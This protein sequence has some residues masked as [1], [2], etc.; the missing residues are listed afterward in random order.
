MS[1]P[2][3]GYPLKIRGT[4]QCY[5]AHEMSQILTFLLDFL[6][7]IINFKFYKLISHS[8]I[9]GSFYREY[10]NVTF[11]PRSMSFIRSFLAAHATPP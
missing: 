6:N 4:K 11:T 8:L 2:N 9:N 7:V 3:G 5:I 1:A 10:K